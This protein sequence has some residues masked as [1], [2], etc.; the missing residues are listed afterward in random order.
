MVPRLRFMEGGMNS[1]WKSLVVAATLVVSGLWA[2]TSFAGIIFSDNFDA[3]VAQGNWAG[4]SVF[5]SIPQ[6]GN[7]GGLP[8]VDLVGPGFFDSL[9]FHPGN[10]VDLDGSTGTGFS[11]AGELQ[12]IQSLAL[13]NYTVSFLLAGNLRGAPAQTTLVAIGGSAPVSFTPL[14][15][16]PYTLETVVFTGV[17]G[18]LTFTDLGPA[19]QQGNLL[20]NVSVASGV[21]ESSTWAMML[22][23]FAGIGFVAYRRAKKGSAAIA[24]S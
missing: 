14:N 2:Q 5:L 23:G 19:T 20:D 24:T 16:Q 4:D 6:P 17:S 13:G 11:P 8:S 15:T 9:A 22:I 18:Q 10:S 1:R 7:V 3:A 12:S 21:P